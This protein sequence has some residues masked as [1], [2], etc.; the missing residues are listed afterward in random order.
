[1][2]FIFMGTPSFGVE[3]LKYLLEHH[4]CL[5]VVTQ[6]DKPVG[7]KRIL[8]PSPIKK[9]ALEKGLVCFQPKRIR[10]I[11]QTLRALAPDFII[12]AAFGQILPQ[13]VLDIPK[14]TCLNLHASILPKYR[15]AAPIQHA[16]KNKD[17][18][19]G[20][21]LMQM[22]L[23]MDAGP[24]YG[25][26]KTKVL[27][28]TFGELFE[29]LSLLARD[30]LVD[31]LDPIIEGT[32]TPSPQDE[33]AMT[34]APKITREDEWLDLNQDASSVMAQLRSLLPLPGGFIYLDGEPLKI[35]EAKEGFENG[36]PGEWVATKKTCQ[37][38]CKTGSLSLMTV[39]PPSKKPMTI[40]AYL[41]G[42]SAS[43]LSS[44]SK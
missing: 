33:K 38:F 34:L 23:K 5:A 16:I 30:C 32:L 36:T 13:S 19:T 10:D 11:E 14:V 40:A 37:V 29:E 25:I 17:E 3:S 4:T 6:P 7:R 39:Q 35:L 22:Q 44:P 31:F 15:G 28:K 42:K 41:N 12:T 43:F 8:T 18:E 9:I 21:S 27:N 1:M 2:R 20:V 24:V 26:K